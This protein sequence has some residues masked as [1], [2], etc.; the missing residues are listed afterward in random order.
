MRRDDE[1]WNFAQRRFRGQGFGFENVKGS[2]SDVPGTQRRDER[3]FVDKSAAGAIDD[4]NAGLRFRESRSVEQVTSFR[5][6]RRV[7]GNEVRRAKQIVELDRK[8]TRLNS[9]H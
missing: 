3:G 6:E 1:I 7:Q 9:S 2:G 8:S 4:A 5:R